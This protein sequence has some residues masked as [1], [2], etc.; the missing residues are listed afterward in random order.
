MAMA[1]LFGDLLFQRSG[2]LPP[3]WLPALGLLCALA[4]AQRWGWRACLGLPLGWSW[5]ALFALWQQPPPL[6]DDWVGQT[7][8][9]DLT[10]LSLPETRPEGSRFIAAIRSPQS[11]GSA[12]WRVRLN[13]RNPP[14]LR[15]GQ[16]YR[17]QLRLKPAHSHHNPGSWDYAGW[18]YRQG[19]RY[20]GYVTAQDWRLLREGDCCPLQTLRQSLREQLSAAALPEAGRAL[21]LALALGDR[22][23]MTREMR[24]LAAL[25]GVSH[26]LA[27]SGLH[28][29]LVGGL[30]AILFAWGWRRT[31][32]AQRVPA[33]LAGALAGLLLAGA[34]AAISGLALPTQRAMLV[35]AVGVLL[36]VQRRFRSAWQVFAIVLLCVLLVQPDAVLEAGLWLSFGAVAAI[37]VMLPQ[38]RSRPWWLALP[39][40][41][42][43]IAVAL[44]PVLLAFDMQTAPL[45]MLYNLLLV[46]LFSLLLIPAALIAAVLTVFLPGLTWPLETVA[47]ALDAIWRALAW[48]AQW[49]PTRLDRPGA[50]LALLSGLILGVVLLLA[51][52][53]VRSRAAGLAMLAIVHF[54]KAPD[55]PAG[56]FRLSVL[57][58]GQG[59][60]AVLQTRHHRLIFDTGAAYPSGYN[61]ADAVVLPWLWRDGINAADRLVLSHG[62]NDHAGAAVALARR[63]RIGRILSGEPAR[64]A[65]ESSLCPSQ[66][67]WRW[68]GVVFGF[69]QPP[70]A[71]RLGGNNASCVLLV[72]GSWGSVLLTGDAEER[73]ERAML[74]Q[75]QRAAPL[76][77]VIAGHHG[78]ATSSSPAFVQVVRARHVIYS[79]GYRNRYGFPRAA[80]DRRW[81]EAGTRRWRTDGCGLIGFDFRSPTSA[82]HGPQTQMPAHRRYWHFPDTPCEMTLPV[83]SS[84][85]GG[86]KSIAD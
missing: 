53:G 80:I 60:S 41:Q 29:S 2:Q 46:P 58:V 15:V 77:V 83:P 26:L 54:P 20:R 16:V 25:T 14:R 68:D 28:I 82:R 69:I 13:W 23:G 40:M 52:P 73:I 71:A 70:W 31:R 61:L 85:I 19:I 32:L 86:L 42:A 43:G 8:A 47:H 38:V 27:I 45:G 55:I 59:L 35:L 50:G 11:G 30:A 17:A 22:S 78:S 44:Y 5:A 33:M 74:A 24:E 7:V 66:Y 9:F 79:V 1:F 4:L 57:D 36:L 72:Q 3:W 81:A 18:L 62:D 34:Y 64:V 48:G 21:L 39:A 76:D 49:S 65:P 67:F 6:P 12:L 51:G 84:M 56:G 63:L 75:L 10:V 37:L